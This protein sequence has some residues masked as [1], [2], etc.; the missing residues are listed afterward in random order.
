MPSCS[1]PSI[2]C[3]SWPILR[4]SHT[5]C[6]IYPVL[7]AGLPAYTRAASSSWAILCSRQPAPRLPPARSAAHSVPSTSQSAAA[8]LYSHHILRSPHPISRAVSLLPPSSRLRPSLLL[9][10]PIDPFMH[11]LRTI[12]A[13]LSLSSMRLLR[14]IVPLSPLLPCRCGRPRL[15]DIS[16]SSNRCASFLFRTSQLVLSGGRTRSSAAYCN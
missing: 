9:H 15:W 16:P 4:R 10:S 6:T 13:P 7:S 1:R 5:S 3:R 11:H 14:S 12:A 2:S 8:I